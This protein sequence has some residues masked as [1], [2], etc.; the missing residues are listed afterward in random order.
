MRGDAL[1]PISFRM[2]NDSIHSNGLTSN[3]VSLKS[4][5]FG[6]NIPG[7]FFGDNADQSIPAKRNCAEN[8]VFDRAD[9]VFFSCNEF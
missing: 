1:G 3:S 5:R 7:L 4:I 2:L 6:Q 8:P 9:S